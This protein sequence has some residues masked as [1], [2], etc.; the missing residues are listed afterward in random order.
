MRRRHLLA[1]VP[2]LPLA[3]LV[4]ACGQFGDQRVGLNLDLR[5]PQGLLDQASGMDLYVFDAA[6]AQCDAGTGH[7][8]KIPTGEATQKF[9][10][11]KKGCTGAD[12]WCTTIQLDK[13]GSKKTFAVVATQAG[14]TVAE[15]CTTQVVDQDPLPV[16]IQAHRYVAPRCCG[17]G[18]L[19]PGE[20]CDTG[21]A[22]AC[23][24]AAAGLCSGMKPDN[25]CACD[26]TAL[27]ILL[28]VDGTDA[29][30]LTNGA[31]GT[32]HDLAIAF[33]PG[34]AGNP[35]MLRTVFENTEGAALGGADI[36]LRDL[37]ETL[38]PIVKPHALGYQLRL[39]LTCDAIAGPGIIRAQHLPTLAVA[40]SDTV[41]VLYQ[42][43]EKLG[44]ED[45]DI[46]LA[47]QT[48]DGCTDTRPCETDAD[49]QTHCDTGTKRCTA[50]IT[51]NVTP[52]GCTEPRAAR[53]PDGQL[54]VTWTRKDGVY[55][56]LWKTDGSLTPAAEIFLAP[57]GSHA[58]VAGT[59]DGFRVVYQGSGA[60]DPDGIYM[61]P[62][63]LS[64]QAG[65]AVLV[66]Q[67]AP[68]LQDQPDIAMLPDGA[69]LVTWHGGGDILFQRFD[70]KGNAVAGDQDA[71]L[72]TSG[73]G[74]AVDQQH[75]VVAA[76]SGF[77]LVAWESAGAITARFVGSASGFG[78]NSVSG[79][80]D[81]FLA[82][83]PKVTGDR[84]G[85]AVA[86][87]SFAVV[88]WEDRAADHHGVYVRRFPAPTQ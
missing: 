40:A 17:D 67:L 11:G 26:C 87:G 39:P 50:A 9:P 27:E 59:K 46:F 72:N 42:S 66:N 15:G 35:T 56:R 60:G 75:P 55:G 82:S 52:G 81:E 8:D 49:C 58:R 1:L 4:G 29:P 2:A 43:D 7:V 51:V 38:D 18:V 57:G 53:G 25:V 68:N 32:K 74:A 78:F 31:A 44:S 24:G 76:G 65:G 71:P 54:L 22:F 37:A 69:T 12:V 79:Q 63:D 86:L 23:D 80:N 83:D 85:P 88:G 20:Q 84:H 5:F 34:G 73:T 3:L 33:G 30:A 13:D 10:L 62:V 77:F 64:G 6:L 19:Q 61:V 28:S 16:H 41:A 45:F 47:P 48:A 70:A 21:V 36:Q 14:V